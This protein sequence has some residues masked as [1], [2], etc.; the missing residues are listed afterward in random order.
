VDLHIN[1]SSTSTTGS[2]NRT[3]SRDSNTT[4]TF[5]ND[6]YVWIWLDV[7]N[8]STPLYRY[9]KNKAN[10][11][12]FVGAFVA[13]VSFTEGTIVGVEWEDDGCGECTNT[14]CVGP[15]PLSNC[16][17]EYT[18][19]SNC[20]GTIEKYTPEL[21]NLKVYLAWLGEDSSGVPMVTYAY[22]PAKFSKYSAEKVVQAVAGTAGD[23]YVP[24]NSYQ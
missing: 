22:T 3:S 8:H 16:G 2:S 21:C 1:G 5:Q 7:A 4:L 10:P 23:N 20:D 24:D 11:G 14:L 13:V 19:V 12:I 6:D 17:Y 15:K 18:A 9:F